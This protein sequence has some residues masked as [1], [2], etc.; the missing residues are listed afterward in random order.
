M[1]LWLG[2]FIVVLAFVAIIKQYE[3][4]AVL[5]GAGLVMCLMAGHPL[6]AFDSFSKMLVSGW[7]V[8]IIVCAMGF[9]QVISLTE[10]D[11]H[12]SYFAL[13]HVLKFK[14]F[15]IP[16]TVIV[17]WILAMAMNSPAGLA[18]TVGPII[19]PVLIRAGI[20]P[21]MAGATLL[22]A[23]WGGCASISSPHIALITGFSHSDV[24]DVVI[25]T[26]PAA[27]AVL[28]VCSIGMVI[29]AKLKKENKGYQL[30]NGQSSEDVTREINSFKVNYLKVLMPLLPLLL[31]I[32]GSK[33]VD[34]IYRF[35]IPQVMLFCTILTFIVTW[36]SPFEV[37]KRFC[38]GMGEGFGSIVSIIAAAAVF[39]AG[40]NEIGLISVLLDAMKSSESLAKFAGS[41]GPFAIAALSGS[42]D[43]ATMAFNNAITP[44]APT[45]GL[46]IDLLGM[47]AYYGGSLGRTISPVAGVCIILAGA[48]GVNPLELSK[49][50]IPTCVV[51][52]F[53]ALLVL[54][55][56]L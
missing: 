12:F 26:F 41:W 18:A 1:L 23:T 40:M 31:L 52:N 13:R 15:L 35:S 27:M 49:R 28:V 3:V 43:A 46:D 24:A 22:V 42:G 32:L 19:I 34:L 9:A 37:S 4:R 56:I 39:T 47:T 2:V 48:A 30:N 11:K 14:V 17:T 20:H 50:V 10:C 7:L 54:Q 8:P 16:G 33:Q 44:H 51:G 55:Y 29:T 36:T 38:K 5:F 6:A 21:A 45:I 53:V 25:R